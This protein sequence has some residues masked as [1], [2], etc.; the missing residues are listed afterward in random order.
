MTTTERPPTP[1][2][3][4][5]R[6]NA[7]LR[8]HDDG[9]LPEVVL[10]ETH[11]EPVVLMPLHHDAQFEL[12]DGRVVQAVGID[13]PGCLKIAEALMRVVPDDDRKCGHCGE[14]VESLD[15]PCRVG[16]AGATCNPSM[17]SADA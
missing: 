12:A 3:D 6:F 15:Q 8:W 16:A 13:L 17:A 14:P 7:L 11:L 5:P 2:A 1:P 9:H 10:D 4:A